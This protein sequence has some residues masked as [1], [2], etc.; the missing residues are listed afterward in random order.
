MVAEVSFN[1]GASDEIVILDKAATVASVTITGSESGAATLALTSAEG[2][3]LTV[4]GQMLTTGNV[5][6]TQ[7][8]DITVR[9]ATKTGVFYPGTQYE[10]TQPVQA[11]FHVH[12]GTWQ[13]LSGTLSVPTDGG[14]LTGEAGISGDGTLIVGGEGASDAKLAVHQLSHI[15]YNETLSLAYG[16]LRV[17]AGGTLTASNAVSLA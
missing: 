16:T 17:A 5:T 11:G 13:I 8:A 9:G 4:S 10:T 7:S 12:Q 2:G 3:S 6:V 1:L 14:N 15:F